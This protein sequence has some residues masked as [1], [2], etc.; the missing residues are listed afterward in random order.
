VIV[1]R[2]GTSA[3]VEIGGE[4]DVHTADRLRAILLD[5]A[6]GGHTRIVADFAGVRFC[7]AAGLG[8]LVAVNNRVREQGGAL[9]LAGV[10]PAQLRILQITRL[11]QLFRPY[12]SVDDALTS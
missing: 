4:I 10:R 8:A 5:L 9:R 7:D 1:H 3:V 12:D 2:D 11:D 6:D